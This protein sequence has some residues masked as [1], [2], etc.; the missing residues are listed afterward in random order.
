MLLPLAGY[1]GYT[2]GLSLTCML[3]FLISVSLTEGLEKVGREFEVLEH[4][5]PCKLTSPPSLLQVIYKKFQLDCPVGRND[6]AVESKSPL[7]LNRSCEAQMFTVDSQVDVQADRV[8]TAL[9]P[10]G[11]MWWTLGLPSI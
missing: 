3:F 6:T 5:L 8:F 10:S 11:A 2:S 1:L 7:G 4:S 9:R